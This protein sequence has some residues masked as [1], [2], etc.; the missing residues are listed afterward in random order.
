[1]NPSSN[2]PQMPDARGV[3]LRVLIAL[4]IGA[5]VTVCFILPAEYRVDPIGI[6][7]AIGLFD[8]TT[9]RVVQT[10]AEAKPEPPKAEPAPVE[11]PKEVA[12]VD[13]KGQAI[14]VL[15]KVG[16]QILRPSPDAFK[17]ETIKITLKPDAELEYK[18]KM[19]A[20]STLLYSWQTDQGNV[21]YDF[22]GEPAD[23][24]KSQSYLEVQE[25]NNANGALVAPF[26]GIHGW[27][28]LNLTSK[29]Q[30]ITLKISGFYESH[31]LV[32]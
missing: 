30:V 22:H 23:P 10:G 15:L 11:A 19:K 7:K 20:G 16:P 24:K 5:I 9:P 12:K 32:K 1:M 25:T 31:G 29:P 17:S 18:V 2:Q 21:Y 6:G 8:L 28:W 4:A 3:M 14:P 26:D 13:E 27:F